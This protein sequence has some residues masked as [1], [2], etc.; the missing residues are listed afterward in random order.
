MYKIFIAILLFTFAL[1]LNNCGLSEDT[2]AKVGN[3]EI[4]AEEFKS[5]LKKQFPDKEN[6]ADVDSSLKMH[7]LK[8]MIDKK[9]KLAA[10]SYCRAFSS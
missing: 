4:K 1:F 5:E 8:Q 6:F 7:L 3:Q 10:V 9:R 2:V